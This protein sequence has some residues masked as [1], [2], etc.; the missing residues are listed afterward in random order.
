MSL[1]VRVSGQEGNGQYEKL[2]CIVL[3]STSQ[4]DEVLCQ[5]LAAYPDVGVVHRVSRKADPMLN[6]LACME[7]VV[8]PEPFAENVGAIVQKIAEEAGEAAVGLSCAGCGE[9]KG[10]DHNAVSK[11]VKAFAEGCRTGGVKHF[12][13]ALPQTMAAGTE[14]APMANCEATVAK[15]GFVRTSMF[16]SDL[17]PPLLAMCGLVKPFSINSLACSMAKDASMGLDLNH[18]GVLDAEELAARSGTIKFYEKEGEG[19]GMEAFAGAFAQQ[20]QLL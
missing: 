14:Q 20:L 6:S 17:S 2:Q 1:S 3:D 7:Q 15:I 4:V 12:L 13:M 10:T 5:F 19:G 18:D 8:V 16:Y 11:A 9:N